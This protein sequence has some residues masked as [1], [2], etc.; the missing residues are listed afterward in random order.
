MALQIAASRQQIRK[1]SEQGFRT[2]EQQGTH[3]PD[4]WGQ[5]L[6]PEFSEIIFSPHSRDPAM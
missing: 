4:T 3:H 6:G 1:S 5:Q 2:T